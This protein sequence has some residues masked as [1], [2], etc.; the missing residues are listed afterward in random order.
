M[1]E[2]PVEDAEEQPSRRPLDPVAF[3][4]RL[5]AVDDI[6]VVGA[7]GVMKGQQ[8][9]RILFEV[10]VDQKHQLASGVRKPRHQ[11][12]VVTEVT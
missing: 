7:H 4:L 6:H 10:A 11:R 2:H 12:F 8:P 5:H 9:G 3:P 1:R